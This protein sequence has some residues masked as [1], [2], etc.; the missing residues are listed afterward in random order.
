MA[1]KVIE[2]AAELGNEAIRRDLPA[3]INES[4][5]L[6]YNLAALWI[7]LG[8]TPADVWREM[9]RR[10]A[11]LGMAEKLPKPASEFE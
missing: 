8:I 5:D 7:G 11:L 9:D 3:L 10:E 2:E 4:A 1:Q 6:F